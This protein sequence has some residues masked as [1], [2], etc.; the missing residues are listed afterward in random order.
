M[1]IR[2]HTS[3]WTEP[4]MKASV[5]TTVLLESL[6]VTV[7]QK[8]GAHPPA[9]SCA[10]GEPP[11]PALGLPCILPAGNPA[12]PSRRCI[13]EQRGQQYDAGLAGRR[14]N[15]FRRYDRTPAWPSVREQL[16]SG[17]P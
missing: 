13:Q 17:S 4:R 12:A 5:A 6:Q 16:R 10:A 2:R 9:A 1:F 8:A 15:S 14:M 11:L 7:G 3:S